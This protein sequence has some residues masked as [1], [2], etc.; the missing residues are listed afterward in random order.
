MI[1]DNDSHRLILQ[2]SRR[3]GT[4]LIERAEPIAAGNVTVCTART[5]VLYHNCS[6]LKHIL[7]VL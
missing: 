4:A 2:A 5:A 6:F 7:T 1:E 3:A